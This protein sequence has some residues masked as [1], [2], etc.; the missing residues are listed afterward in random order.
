MA[1]VAWAQHRGISRVEVR[2]DGG[3]WQEATLAPAVSVDTW[4]QWSWRWPATAGEH[5][6]QVRATDRDGE[7]QTAAGRAGGPGRRHRLAQRHSHRPLSSHHPRSS[8][9]IDMLITGNSPV[10]SRVEAVGALP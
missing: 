6:L 5:T 3:G 2:V 7:T 9:M 8:I 4:V 10:V 1:G